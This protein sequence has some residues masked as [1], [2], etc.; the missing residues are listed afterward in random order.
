MKSRAK[1]TKRLRLIARTWSVPVIAY[2]F[3]FAGGYFVS[4]VTTGTADPHA[5]PDY[6]FIENLPPLFLFAA[7]IG[8]LIAWWREKL[9]SLIN[10]SFCLAALVIL[11][12]HW[13]LTGGVRNLV[14]YGL[15]VI[16]VVPGIL[17]FAYWR[18]LDKSQGVPEVEL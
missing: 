11:L 3:L 7:A 9:G 12:I 2:V 6:P 4:W 14:P 8:L 15:L 10:L 17:F 18:R 16:V 5:V 13:P 1:N